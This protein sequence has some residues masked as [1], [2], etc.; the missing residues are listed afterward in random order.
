MGVGLC[1]D[2]LQTDGREQHMR[3]THGSS[4]RT[5]GISMSLHSMRYVQMGCHVSIEAQG[6]SE[7]V[8]DSLL[9]APS[10]QWVAAVAAGVGG[11]IQAKRW[12]QQRCWQK[13]V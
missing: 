7:D 12:R 6:P 9:T 4:G 10:L 2:T 11:V 1:D 5:Q 3:S 13:P 8:R